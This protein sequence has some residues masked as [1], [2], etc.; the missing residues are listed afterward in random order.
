MPNSVQ[1]AENLSLG[2]GGKKN[3]V[4]GNS[5]NRRLLIDVH[6]AYNKNLGGE[7]V[8]GGSHADYPTVTEL[9]QG[10]TNYY[11]CNYYRIGGSVTYS[12]QVSENRRMNLFAKVVF[13][14]VNTSDYDYDGRTYLSIS[15]GC[16]F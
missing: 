14:R 12:Q 7:Y 6:I 4:L 2:L 3:F 13:D 8:Y 11:T 1:N 15:L 9:Q 5:L 16:N 10:L